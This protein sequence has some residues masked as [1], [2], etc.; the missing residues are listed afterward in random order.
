MKIADGVFCHTHT[1][2]THCIFHN[3]IAHITQKGI[4][5]H[6]L[7]T[8]IK[9]ANLPSIA[10]V[11]CSSELSPAKRTHAHKKKNIIRCALNRTTLE[12]VLSGLPRH[13]HVSQHAGLRELKEKRCKDGLMDTHK[14]GTWESAEAPCNASCLKWN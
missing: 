14:C 9:S 8:F 13:I 2:L 4:H 5:V 1:I 3:C 11:L 10:V 7:H 12:G 6:V